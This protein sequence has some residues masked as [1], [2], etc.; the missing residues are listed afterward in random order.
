M[1][2]ARQH[3]AYVEQCEWLERATAQQL[4]PS[5]LEEKYVL[6]HRFRCAAR[7]DRAPVFLAR[8]RKTLNQ[9]ARGASPPTRTITAKFA[10]SAWFSRNGGME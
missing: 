1:L 5:E 8:L 10:Y 7:V 3:R 9:F 4:S 2:Y 6:V